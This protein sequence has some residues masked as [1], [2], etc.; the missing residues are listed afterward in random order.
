[1]LNNIFIKSI[2]CTTCHTKSAKAIACCKGT[3]RASATVGWNNTPSTSTC[4]SALR[5]MRHAAAWSQK[6]KNRTKRAAGTTAAAP[7]RITSWFCTA[8]APPVTIIICNRAVPWLASVTTLSPGKKSDCPEIPDIRRCHTCTSP[9][10]APQ[11]GAIRN[12]SP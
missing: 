3:A 6:L 7:M 4:L 9:F 8:M 5:Y 10:I 1:M 12:P 11:N 2:T